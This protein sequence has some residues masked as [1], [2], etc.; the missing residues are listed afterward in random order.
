MQSKKERFKNT[1]LDLAQSGK[2]IP[3]IYNYCD[4]WCERCTM[5][6]KCLN[7]AHEQA[8]KEEATDPESNDI[9]NEK[10]WESLS[11]SFQ[12][13]FELL[14]EDAKRFGIDLNNLPEVEIKKPEKRPVEILSKKYSTQMLKWL[15]ANN[16]KLKEKAEQLL[17]IGNSEEPA[18]KF[19]DAWEVVQWY[20]VFISAKVHRSHFD[21]DER[22][23]EPEDEYDLMSDNLGSAKIALIAIDRSVAALSAMY[24]VMPEN[25]DD[26]LK[27]LSHLSQIKKLMLETF[28]DAMNFKRPGFD[29]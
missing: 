23:A 21:L 9:S 6:S 18:L 17:L 15:Q 7:Y 12:V 5:S 1:L 3:G 27:F 4:R 11:L 16:E 14:E 8:M 28:P 2:F 22:L 13:T 10:F 24:S 25:E 20:S 29:S 26:Y 19:A